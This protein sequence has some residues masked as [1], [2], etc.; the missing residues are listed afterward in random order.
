[1]TPEE[2]VRQEVLYQLINA[3]YF[4]KQDIRT[5][6]HIRLG[7]S[8]RRVDIAVFH[9]N[10]MHIQQ[11]ISIIIECKSKQYIYMEEAA[12]QV[13]SY[14]S[15]CLNAHYGVVAG[16]K[17]LYWKRVQLENGLHD[18][19]EIADIPGNPTP[20]DFIPTKLP[21]EPIRVIKKRVG[22]T[23]SAPSRSSLRKAKS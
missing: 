5:E 18:L 15:A 6:F 10:T 23:E 4:N 13:F 2:E 17:N 11:N 1:M 12:N 16:R 3:Y 22:G 7:S 21:K 9:P 14:L 8:T 20:P 19:Q